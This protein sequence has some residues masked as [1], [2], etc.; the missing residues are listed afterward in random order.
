[1]TVVF[2]FPHTV[3]GFVRYLLLYCGY[4]KGISNAPAKGIIKKIKTA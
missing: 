4:V 3:S 1:M 2:K